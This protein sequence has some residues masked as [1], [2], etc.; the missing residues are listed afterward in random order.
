MF[1]KTQS[2]Q[3]L[4]GD[5]SIN[6]QAQNI[7]QN[8]IIQQGINAEQAREIATQVYKENFYQLTNEA[9]AVA[10]LRASELVNKLVEQLASTSTPLLSSFNDPD[11]Q[12]ALVQSQIAYAR[13]GDPNMLDTLINILV[14]RAAEPNRSLVQIVLNESLS[15][16]PKLTKAQ[17]DALS[18]VFMLKHVNHNFTS[19][20]MLKDLS[21]LRFFPF[22][23]N[24][25]KKYSCYQHLVYSSCC[26]ISIGEIQIA[27]IFSKY[28][29]GLFIRGFELS[30]F[31]RLQNSDLAKSLLMK[32]LNNESLFQ[33]NALNED[34][35]T[36]KAKHLRLDS[37]L[38]ESLLA[39]Q[40]SKI[41]NESEIED[42]LVRLDN[43]Y[44]MLF[45][46]WK[47]SSLKN[48]NLTS[49]GIAIAIANIKQSI[50]LNY[51]L[52]EWID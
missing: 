28:Y 22:I 32:C 18:M 49:V 4:S 24:L 45:D 3:Q 23:D 41:M 17:L 12:Y 27:N 43:R 39:L 15:V 29:P 16:L 13:T 38:I 33:I 35:I 37:A 5:N 8:F 2:Q 31:S 20:N 9:K 26:S 46:I 6:N 50:G 42:I 52:S 36:E 34:V 19:L 25:T 51:N 1:D 14:Q 48:I 21:N 40:R 10:D 30:E 44:S 7:T 47:N 11:M